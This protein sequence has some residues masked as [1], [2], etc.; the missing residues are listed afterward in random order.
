MVKLDDLDIKL[1]ELVCRQ[2]CKFYKEGQELREKEYQC[3]A[4]KFLK[5]Y[6]E[7]GQLTLNDLKNFSV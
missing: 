7:K 3:G 4:Y 5:K 2:K 6:I 1:L